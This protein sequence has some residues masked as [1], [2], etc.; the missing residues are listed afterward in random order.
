MTTNSKI[1][2]SLAL[3][4]EQRSHVLFVLSDSRAEQERE[5]LK[6]YQ[7]EYRKAISK[8]AHVLTAQHYERHEIDITQGRFACLPFKYLALYELSLDGVEEAQSVI[9]RVVSLHR[10]QGA[11][12]DPAS[13]LYYPMS[14]KVGRAP[15]IRPSMLT[16][17][18]ANAVPGREEDFREWYATRHIRHALKVPAL[19]SGQCFA[20]TQFQRDGALECTFAIIAMYEQEGTPESIL[21]SFKAIPAGALSFPALD[22]TPGRFSEWVYRPISTE[23]S[24]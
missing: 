15:I 16:M 12:H 1:T 4:K 9:D 20:R 8:S 22:I 13:W 19:V 7:G 3:L 10:E 21:E 2:N 18:F 14:E 6:W 23:G 11:A 5:F 17:A 24:S